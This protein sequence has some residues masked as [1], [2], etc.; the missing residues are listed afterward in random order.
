MK[1][2]ERFFL[3]RR[4][5]LGMA[6]SSLL[7]PWPLRGALA[8]GAYPSRSVKILVPFAPG[9]GNDVFARLIAQR[10]TEAWSHSVVVENRAGAGG[11]IGTAE[12][13]RSAP[14]GYTL[15]LGHTGTLS[16]NPPLYANLPYDVERD[17]QPIISFCATPLLLVVNPGQSIQSL[18]DLLAR[19]RS[20][21]EAISF[22]SGGQG[23]GAH[24]TGELFASRIGVR[25]LHVPY[26]GTLPA[27]T[28][29]AA[30]HIAMMFSVGPP[31]LPLIKA[32]KLK[33][34]AVTGTQR[35]PSLAETPTMIEAGL[36][37]FE[38]SLT[39][40]V[41]APRGTPEAISREVFEQI[42]KV[43]QSREFQERMS[44]EGAIAQI[45]NATQFSALIRS[46]T[47]KWAKLIQMAGIKPQ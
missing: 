7:L 24:L 39:Y 32:G 8:Q 27:L 15:L 47:V 44:N 10:L 37:D 3:K 12:A 36:P 5:A 2:S 22:G 11:N 46:E 6:V 17:L 31:A 21:P 23:T 38:S 34:L 1:I 33:V 42:V 13:A 41:L 9:G 40:G 29:I 19:A 26:K 4:T 35:L 14:D 45:G 20:K 18:A 28:D 16:I 43:A 30:G 25:L